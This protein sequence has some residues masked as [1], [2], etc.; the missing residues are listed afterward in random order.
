M[1]CDG[2]DVF[3]CY[4]SRVWYNKEVNPAHE[5]VIP[6]PGSI[7]GRGERESIVTLVGY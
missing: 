3:T 4:G 5:D 7:A 1:L 2:I 6:A